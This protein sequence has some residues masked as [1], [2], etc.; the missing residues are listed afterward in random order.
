MSTTIQRNGITFTC[1][2]GKKKQTRPLST[3]RTSVAHIRPSLLSDPSDVPCRLRV[4]AQ[5]HA[6]SS[7][8]ALPPPLSSSNGGGCYLLF[9]VRTV[10][11][12]GRHKRTP[13]KSPSPLS[14]PSD[15]SPLFC[16]GG[17]SARLFVLIPSWLPVGTCSKTHTAH[18]LSASFH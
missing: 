17:A 15:G 1:P 10:K 12:F 5:A 7:C 18:R 9:R 4:A 14:S 6:L 2:K 8:L 3:R 11:D 13:Y 16:L